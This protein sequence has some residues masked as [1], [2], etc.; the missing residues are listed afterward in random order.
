MGR[1]LF[2]QVCS[3]VGGG[4]GGT[5]IQLMGGRGYFYPADGGGVLPHWDWRYPLSG[6]DGGNPSRQSTC[7]VADGMPLEFTQDFLHFIFP[8]GS[9]YSMHFDPVLYLC[10]V[11]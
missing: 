3:L 10:K 5:L 8:Y 4:G 6:L 9:Y 1:V 7:Y 2:S 11:A